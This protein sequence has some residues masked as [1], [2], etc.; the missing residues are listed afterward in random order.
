MGATV[1]CQKAAAAFWSP[2]GTPIHVL[3][4]STYEKNVRPHTPSWSCCHIGPIR[5]ALR[6]VFGYA[7]DCEGGMLQTPRGRTS[8]EAYIKR[9]L[10]HLAA[11]AAMPDLAV[12]LSC[13]DAC[14][15]AVRPGM[16]AD[17]VALLA[18]HGLAEASRTL[19]AGGTAE[20]RLHRDADAIADLCDA[21]LVSP[22]RLVAAAWVPSQPAD[23]PGLGYAPAPIAR[24]LPAPP[25]MLKLGPYE[26]L[27]QAGDSAWKRAGWAYTILG[28][29]VGQAWE[30]ELAAPGQYR[31]SISALRRAVK[32]A[33]QVPPG[34]QVLVH[35]GDAMDPRTQRAWAAITAHHQPEA[36]EAGWLLPATPDVASSLICNLGEEHLTWLVPDGT[37]VGAAPQASLPG[38]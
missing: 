15:H 26:H 12:S 17:T 2:S 4:E 16:L 34:T 1:T 13:G 29:H 5:G 9:W 37:G 6:R 38:T 20:L 18:G 10:G 22:H 24:A 7:S 32:A 27:V 31:R 30:A 14:S 36:V 23:D 21:R 8:P 3:F 33:P 35:S 19:Q 25:A 11:P 28:R